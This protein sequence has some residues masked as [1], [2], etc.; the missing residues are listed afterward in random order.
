M[1]RQV[2]RVGVVGGVLGGAIMA[3]WSMGVLWF[4]GLGFWTVLNLIAHTFVR[5]VPIDSTFNVTGTVLGTV[6]HMTVAVVIGVGLTAIARWAALPVPV[7]ALVGAVAVLTIWLFMQFVL[8]MVIDSV[9]AQSFT[10]WVMGVGH[11]TYGMMLVGAN[12]RAAP[13]QPKPALPELPSRPGGG[14]RVPGDATDL[15]TRPPRRGRD[16]TGPRSW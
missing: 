9:A 16:G 8:W 6:I 4:T 1:A 3:V 2:I 15:F 12:A 7:L 11:L 13:R 5:S 10:P 14:V